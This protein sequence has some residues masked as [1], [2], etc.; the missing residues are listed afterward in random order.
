MLVLTRK[1]GESIHIG[2]GVVVTVLDVRSNRIRLGIDAP[3]SIRV[4]RSECVCESDLPAAGTITIPLS[5]HDEEGAAEQSPSPMRHHSVS[6]NLRGDG[7]SPFPMAPARRNAEPPL[8]Y[9]RLTHA[10]RMIRAA[11]RPTSVDPPS[12]DVPADSGKIAK[13]GKFG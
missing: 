13:L 8:A 5:V 6:N 9:A 10:A 1:T 4:Q 7:P 2:D 12:A 3:M 11:G